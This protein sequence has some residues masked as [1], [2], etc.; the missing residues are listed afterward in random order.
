MRTFRDFDGMTPARSG[1]LVDTSADSHPLSAAGRPPMTNRLSR[2]AEIPR[3]V[4]F[5][6]W[7]RRF[8][9][10]AHGRSGSVGL[11]CLLSMVRQI[12][13]APD[14]EEFGELGLGVVAQVVQL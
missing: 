4:D 3:R 9:R 13:I 1:Q 7:K 8:Q 10:S 5:S 12:V 6:I 14:A 2:P 11:A